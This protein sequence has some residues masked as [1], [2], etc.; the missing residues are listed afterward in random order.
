LVREG[1]E[2]G[3]VASLKATGLREMQDGALLRRGLRGVSG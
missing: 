1:E 2:E 3:V